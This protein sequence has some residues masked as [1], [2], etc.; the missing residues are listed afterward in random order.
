LEISNESLEANVNDR[1]KK[2]EI[3]NIRLRKYAFSN[4]HEVRAP[5]ARLLGLIQLWNK[6]SITETDRDFIIENISV[7]TLELDEVIKKMS[8]LLNE[9]E[10]DS[11]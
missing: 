10:N 2:I 6:E 4:A 9:E 5:V 3:Q 11:I 8:D 7:S 1:T